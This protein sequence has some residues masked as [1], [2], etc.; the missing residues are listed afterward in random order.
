VDAYQAFL[1]A[2]AYIDAENEAYAWLATRE[3]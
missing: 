3:R 1:L 2:D